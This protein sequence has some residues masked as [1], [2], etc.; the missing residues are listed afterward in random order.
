MP[1]IKR[2]LTEDAK[3]I[4]VIEDKRLSK[5]IIDIDE[6]GIIAVEMLENWHGLLDG[7]PVDMEGRDISKVSNLNFDITSLYQAIIDQAVK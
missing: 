5:I 1:I 4:F 2:K 3:R 6:N 7:N